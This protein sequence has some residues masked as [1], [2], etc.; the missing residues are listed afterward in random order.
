MHTD[1]RGAQVHVARHCGA[2]LDS[3][4]RQCARA[5]KTALE[6]LQTLARARVAAAFHAWR[7]NAEGVTHAL[8]AAQLQHAQVC[9][10]WP[11]DSVLHFVKADVK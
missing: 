9:G 2:V 3:W 8:A 4:H 1:V 5:R 10:T 7:R 11:S 6:R